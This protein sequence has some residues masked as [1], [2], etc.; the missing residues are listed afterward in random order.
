MSLSLGKLRESQV[1]QVDAWLRSILWENEL[2]LDESSHGA[3]FEIHRLKGRL[4]MEEGGKIKVIQG[5]R[6]LFEIFDPPPAKAG[7]GDEPPKSSKIVLI[8]R[9]LGDFDFEKSLKASLE[10]S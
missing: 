7:G 4:V 1:D 3:Q 10:T 6:E 5:V 2:P 8:G 9:H